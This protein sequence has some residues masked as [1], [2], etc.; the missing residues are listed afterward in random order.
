V[1]TGNAGGGSPTGT[2]TFY[3]CGPTANATP[4]T[5][6]TNQVGTAVT[7][8]A[9]AGN[10]SSAQSVTFTPH[11]TGYYCFGA[12]YSG[13]SNYSASSDT[14][15][16]ECFDV[17]SATSGTTST[18]ASSSISAGST[19]TD[20]A[21]VAGNSAGGAPTGTVT[22]YE[23]GPTA[24]AT[25]CTSQA[26][27]VGTAV[28]LTA[29]AGDV[30]N[31]SSASITA[32]STGYYCFGAYY[33]GD[34]NYSASSDTST[35]DC[36]DVTT[37]TSAT[38]STPT[39]LD[40]LLG[41]SN[42]DGA[43]VTGNSAVGAPTGTVTFYE[44]GATPNRTPCTSQA[45]EVGSPVSVTTGGG[46]TSS[47][48]SASFTPDDPG[49]YCFGAYYSGDSN[50][51]PSSDTST[52]ECFDVGVS[53]SSTTSAPTHS[54]I[55]L[56]NT[57]TDGAVVTGNAVAGPPTGT[58][59]FY[60]CQPTV[61]PTSCTSQ[62]DQVGSPVSLTAGAGHTSSAQSVTFTPTSTGYWCFGAYYSGDSN[63]EGSTDTS[64][65]ECF[66]VTAAAST[67]SSLPAS[68]RI[69][70]GGTNSDNVTVAGNT[71]GGA[72]TGTVTFYECGPTANAT[73]CSSQ[74]NEV[75]TP[76]TLTAGPGDVSYA[77]SASAT[78]SSAG[79]YCFAAY[80][81][82]SSDYAASSD[83]ATVECFV[84]AAA[85][86]ITSFSPASGAPGVTVTI[87]GTNLTDATKVTFGGVAATVIS[88]DKATKIVVKVPTGAKTGKIKVV[89]AGG[90]ATSRT[91]FTV[92]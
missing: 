52:D 82:G 78:F 17:T 77:S 2:V 60:V 85:P 14:S 10:T 83:T 34:S 44:C 67:T 19:N 42:T 61:S 25:P 32:A 79:T 75:G 91:K 55:V 40:I 28:T 39:N 53:A 11:A 81:S 38:T 62:A 66:K 88:V 18:P 72:P 26:N 80:Y 24:N 5:S 70:V 89:T 57:N 92:T 30:S 21:S 59:T 74:T 23:C 13:D 9:G 37:A 64:T 65:D 6:Q 87:V 4:C 31:A 41:N 33:S 49:Y 48:Q 63:Y 35:D 43:V 12:Y 71:P 50:Y 29:G 69:G 56:G 76:V 36:F 68:S 7:V 22:F 3:E 27:E 20:N 58:V 51:L 16:D 1:V 73:P 90:T 8:T 86:T 46:D 15:T 47:A 45:H 84:V 54:S